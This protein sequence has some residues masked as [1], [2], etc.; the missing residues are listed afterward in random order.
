MVG[1]NHV[2]AALGVGRHDH[3]RRKAH[4]RATAEPN[5]TDGT[6]PDEPA[7]EKAVSNIVEAVSGKPLSDRGKKIGGTIAHH[8]FGA[9][10][11]ALYGAAATRVPR[12]AI[13]AGA[14]YGAVVWLTATEAGVPLAGLSKR[15]A[16]YPPA[17][18]A[19]SLATHV[20]FGITVDAVR[21][22]LARR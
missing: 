2:V 22:W 6:I 21:R 5:E 18:H 3:G 15:P 14:V 9:T 19:A 12:L 17:R 13:G 8:A 20:V 7:S 1:F 16:A 10:L 4:R 11:G